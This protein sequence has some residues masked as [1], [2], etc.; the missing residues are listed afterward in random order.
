MNKPT[1]N[2]PKRNP[3]GRGLSALLPTTSALGR[4]GHEGPGGSDR[5]RAYFL[6]PIED[7]RPADDNPRHRFDEERLAEL[8]SSIEQQGIIQPLVVRDAG[9]GAFVLIAGE[10]RWR[11][12]QKAGL[13]EVP[14]VVKDVT[15]AAAFELALVENL[16][17][18]DLSPIEEAEGYQRLVEEF[19][20][21]QESL[22][23]RVGKERSTV[24]NA[25]R[26]L[27]LPDAV[28]AM[29]S[30]GQLQMGHARALLGLPNGNERDGQLLFQV[31]RRVVERG[32]SVRQ[33][34][35]LVRKTRERLAADEQGR[36]P[37]LGAEAAERSPVV[38]DL[39]ARLARHLGARVRVSARPDGRGRIEI[40]YHSLDELDRLL[41]QL[42]SGGLT[43]SHHA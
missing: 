8:A 41:E 42:L 5:R 31:A 25:L 38:R 21:T 29:V 14:V 11:A 7:V 17:R 35:E 1:T 22:A 34:E 16:Q 3:L 20:Y 15:P 13:L 10:R 26:L 27:K 32:F 33:T 23:Q 36:A 12:A 40:D 19:G 39:E 28:R 2:P 4:D 9:N 18:E 43:T 6:C 24:A 37:A 30:A